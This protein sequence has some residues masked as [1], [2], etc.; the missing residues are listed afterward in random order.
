MAEDYFDVWSVVLPPMG[1]AFAAFAVWLGARIVNRRERWAKHTAVWLSVAIISYLVSFGPASYLCS[2]EVISM[3]Q[4]DRGY[5]PMLLMAAKHPR[6][7]GDGIEA[8]AALW[9]GRDAAQ[10]AITERWMTMTGWL[11]RLRD[12]D[13][14]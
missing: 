8:Y 9:G 2:V 4:F 5:G 6:T 12:S 7:I 14:R 3:A 11:K 10:E 13:R 1:A